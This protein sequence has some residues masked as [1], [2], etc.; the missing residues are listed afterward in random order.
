MI[1]RPC[2]VI[3]SVEGDQ[4]RNQKKPRETPRTLIWG[5]LPNPDVCISTSIP[6][7]P[8]PG[9]QTMPRLYDLFSCL[10]ILTILPSFV[11][12]HLVEV[13]AGKKECFFE[14]LHINDK[15]TVT[16]QVAEGGY[17]DVDF[18]V[19]TSIVFLD[20]IPYQSFIQLT[21]PAGKTLGKQIRQT[22]GSY[23]ITA[24]HDGRHEYCFSN[25]MSAVADKIVR[26][27]LYYFSCQRRAY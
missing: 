27:V 5:P 6:S 24:E 1:I 16:Y 19:G 15:M 20:P 21:D 9:L 10:F 18:W 25:Q 13:T 26:H 7:E 17:L 23:A 8:I 3:L 4:F 11:S 22:T 14:D 2:Y 12:A